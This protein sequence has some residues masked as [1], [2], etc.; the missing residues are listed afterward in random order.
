MTSEKDG[1]QLPES[2]LKLL[3]PRPRLV[4]DEVGPDLVVVSVQPPPGSG[5]AQPGS[6]ADRCLAEGR[7]GKPRS[8]PP[9]PAPDSPG[10]LSRASRK[11]R[12]F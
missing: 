6:P 8:G 4:F 10:R 12:G 5:P 11:R 7:G 1:G 2:V 3:T 9:V